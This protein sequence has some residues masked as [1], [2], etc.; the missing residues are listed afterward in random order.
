MSD[1]KKEQSKR[2]KLNTSGLTG[3]ISLGKVSLE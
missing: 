2:I 3:L 1:D